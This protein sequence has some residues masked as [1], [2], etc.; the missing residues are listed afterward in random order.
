[1]DTRGFKGKIIKIETQNY[2]LT[3]FLIKNGFLINLLHG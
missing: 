2:V 1:M 3:W